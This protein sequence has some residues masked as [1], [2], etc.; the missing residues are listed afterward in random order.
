MHGTTQIASALVDCY[1]APQYE[2]CRYQDLWLMRF[3][4]SEPE[5][6]EYYSL[7]IGVRGS[8]VGFPARPFQNTFESEPFI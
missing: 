4:S 1:H 5:N 7:Y 6:Q 2:S 3:Q 8:P